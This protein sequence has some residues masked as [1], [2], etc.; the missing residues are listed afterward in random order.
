VFVCDDAPEHRAL[1]RAVL[2]MESAVEVVGEAA[3][4]AECL[5]GV[6]ATHPDVLV[7]D[8]QMPRVDGWGVLE[9]LHGEGPR[10]LVMSSASDVDER[11]RATG[12]EFLPKGRPPTD[13]LDAVRRLAA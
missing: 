6:A 2:D 3:D 11:V 7:L 9:A 13:L 10:V 8:L 5:E 1:V 12:A 4:G